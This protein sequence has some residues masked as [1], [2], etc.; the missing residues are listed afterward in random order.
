MK[1]AG[2]IPARFAST[3]F[4][5]KP[6]VDILGKSMIIRVVEQAK[7]CSDLDCVLV[8]TDD[9][10]IA[11]HVKSHGA[12]AVLTSTAH[13]SGT[14]RCN[15]AVKSISNS[16]DAV[17]NIQGDEPF[18]DPSQISV[19][20]KLIARPEVEIA[21]L[22]KRID[23][24]EELRDPNKVKVVFAPSGRAIYF[25]RHAIPFQ[26][27]IEMENWL[28]HFHYFRHIGL[29]AYKLPVLEEICALSPSPLEQA[30]SLEQLRWLENGRSIYV[31]ETIIDTPAIDTPQ[32]LQAIIESA[33]TPSGK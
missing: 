8:A 27:G 28:G 24:K 11:D 7:K 22:A 9:V 4:P 26:K 2:I 19:V 12:D 6:L 14:D 23:K 30:E 15:E 5:G 20:A 29:Y 13:Q 16:V 25:S 21:T 32:D 10:R 17:V 18:L 33:G 31:A 3:R 1:I